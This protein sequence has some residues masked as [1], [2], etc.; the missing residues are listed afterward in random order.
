MGP[1]GAAGARA[2]RLILIGGEGREVERGYRPERI[3]V[4]KFFR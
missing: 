1:K 4:L 2:K 3:G